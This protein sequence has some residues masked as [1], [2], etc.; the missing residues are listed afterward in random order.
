MEVEELIEELEKNT[1]EVMKDELNKDPM[2]IDGYDD[3][4][5]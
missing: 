5:L 3:E 2:N 4:P 1:S